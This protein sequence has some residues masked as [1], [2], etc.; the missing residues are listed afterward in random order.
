MGYR[1]YYQSNH[2]VE[3]DENYKSLYDTV[4]EVYNKNS[5]FNEYCPRL[6]EEHIPMYVLM[7][8]ARSIS[9]DLFVAQVP[10]AKLDQWNQ[11]LK[12]DMY[13]TISMFWDTF[14]IFEDNEKGCLWGAVYYC[15]AVRYEKDIN[16]PLM[17][18]IVSIGCKTK[19]AMPY[20]HHFQAA[21]LNNCEINSNFTDF[22]QFNEKMKSWGK[23]VDYVPS[24][25]ISS[26]EVF[27][28]FNELSINERC[29]ARQVFNDVLS[30]SP[31]WQSMCKEM[32]RR[33]WFKERVNPNSINYNVEGDYVITKT[34]EN[35]VN[36]VAEGGVGIKIQ[37]DKN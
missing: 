36:G 8:W 19:V 7:N 32:K 10:S 18:R 29:R 14:H 23:A 33:G 9:E 5:L 13:S 35:E 27:Y 17:L 2:V 16:D 25:A 3:K 12:S 22:Q 28:G 37:K 26:T 4:C 30:D 24:D 6:A 1:A 15:L 11:F 20:F 21:A 34:V 31:A